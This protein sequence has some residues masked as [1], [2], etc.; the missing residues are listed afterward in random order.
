[1]LKENRLETSVEQRLKKVRECFEEID[2]DTFLVIV[3][4]NRR[5]LSDFTGEDT[6]F[7]ES[8]GALFISRTRSILATDSRYE[9]QAHNES[10]LFEILCYR[11]GLSKAIPDILTT[12]KT[13]RLG[14]EGNRLSYRQ[15]QEFT[16]QLHSRNQTIEYIEANN[17]VEKLRI[18]KAES[19]IRETQNA[20]TL[21]ET[22]FQEFAATIRPGMMEKDAAWAMERGMREAGADSLSFPTIVASGPNSALPHAVPGNRKIKEGEPILFDWG[23]KLNGY[24]SDI[25]RT[26]FIGKPDDTFKKVFMTVFEA[27]KKAIEA[28]QPGI[29]SKAI[30][31]IARHYIDNMG[32]KGKFGHG[33][34][35]GTGLAIHES[36]RLSPMKDTILE[37]GMVFTVEPG[38]YIPDWGGVRLENMVVVKEKGVEVLNKLN[39]AD[40]LIGI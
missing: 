9:L 15:Y 37:P 22:V 18:I 6:Q 21:A 38:I 40:F 23:A 33:L 1:V 26:L 3:G 20:L 11:E 13:K 28:I 32:F 39:V 10:P 24:C 17:I 8:A 16:E 4:E 19:E 30:D 2:I 12:L 35:H 27:Q 25:S 31:E 36:P 29:S 14:F 5:Y 7:D 34:G